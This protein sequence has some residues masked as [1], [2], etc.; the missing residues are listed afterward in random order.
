MRLRNETETALTARTFPPRRQRFRVPS[1]ISQI[2]GSLDLHGR[3]GGREDLLDL[4]SL[5][6]RD[7]LLDRLW[8]AFDEVLGLLEAQARDGADLLDHVDLLVA[9][10]HEDDVELGLLLGG[11]GAGRSATRPGHGRNHPRKI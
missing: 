11:S 9:G 5:L 1:R 6:L 7:A 4:L 8:S 2:R 10:V 3:P